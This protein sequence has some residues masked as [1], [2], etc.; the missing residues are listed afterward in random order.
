MQALRSSKKTPCSCISRNSSIDFYL[1]A[2]MGKQANILA[3]R[4]ARNVYFWLLLISTRLDFDNNPTTISITGLLFLLLAILFY[5]NNLLL[6]P[7]LLQRK[8]YGKYLAGYGVLSLLVSFLYT[9]VLKAMLVAHPDWHVGRVSAIVAGDE[10]PSFAIDAFLVDWGWYFVLLSVASAV[11]AMSWYVTDYQRQQKIIEETKKEHLEMQLR[12]L[13]SQVNPHFLFNS[14]NNLYTLTL[15]KSDAASEVVAGLSDILRYLLYESDTR[16]VS[17]DREKEVIEAYVKLE[18][19]RLQNTHGMHFAI[20][21]DGNYQVPPLL[22]LPLLENV[23]KHGT[24]F[25]SAEHAVH[26]SFSVS[27]NVIRIQSRNTFK[28][29]PA[30]TAVQGMG[31]KN[32]EQRLQLIFGEGYELVRTIDGDQYIAAITADLGCIKTY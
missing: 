15:Q 3:G 18:L 8:K 32:L 6:I 29:T 12:F 27:E 1:L 10:T 30:P 2:L 24:R 16:L 17:F 25:I 5:I 20:T 9:C 21:A 7:R 28:V 23:F 13:K 22:W 11:F 26:F 4:V 14:L 31:L 19:L